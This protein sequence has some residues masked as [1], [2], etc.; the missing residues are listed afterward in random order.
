MDAE[1]APGLQFIFLSCG[2]FFGQ[3]EDN[4]GLADSYDDKN[5]KVWLEVFSILKV[6]HNSYPA[7]V[8]HW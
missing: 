1:A 6:L 7:P 4:S 8:K 5:M 2:F 3:N